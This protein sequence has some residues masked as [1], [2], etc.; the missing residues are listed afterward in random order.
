MALK[1]AVMAPEL[2]MP[3]AKVVM[4]VAES[5]PPTKMPSTLATEIVPELVM[6]PPALPPNW[7]MSNTTMP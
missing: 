7:L 5:E 1:F 2:V 4:P 6:P 3:P